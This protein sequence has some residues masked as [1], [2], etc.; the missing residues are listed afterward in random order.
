MIGAS[1]PKLYSTTIWP[2]HVSIYDDRRTKPSS[3][4]K[5]VRLGVHML[6][7][8]IYE[9][10]NCSKGCQRKGML[11][12]PQSPSELIFMKTQFC[13]ELLFEKDFFFLKFFEVTMSV[14]GGTHLYWHSLMKCSRSVLYNWALTEAVLSEK[15]PSERRSSTARKHTFIKARS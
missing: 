2:W 8:F 7:V 6:G 5:M 11:S 14:T 1:R 4:Q 15:T 13:W 9:A 10:K 12:I 3:G